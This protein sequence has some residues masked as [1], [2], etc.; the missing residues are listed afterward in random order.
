MYEKAWF[1]ILVHDLN[2]I[3]SLLVQVFETQKYSSLLFVDGWSV[4]FLKLIAILM[5][6]HM[7][8]VDN[9]AIIFSVDV[10]LIS[11]DQLENVCYFNTQ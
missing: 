1:T 4:A 9:T 5:I 2:C 8:I 11:K 3:V 6:V 10:A 7:Y